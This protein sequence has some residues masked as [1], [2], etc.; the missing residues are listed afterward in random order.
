MTPL[1]V[2]IHQIMDSKLYSQYVVNLVRKRLY[3]FFFVPLF[4]LSPPPHPSGPNCLRPFLLCLYTV[5]EYSDR[6]TA[7]STGFRF[8]VVADI[9]LPAATT[10]PTLMSV[11]P[12]IQQ[13]PEAL[14][15]VLKR[16]E[17]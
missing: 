12:L 14:S 17:R 16:P 9:F 10:R 11:Q 4:P 8:Q 6:T 15:T 7:S 5:G 3:C 13:L 1:E 2:V